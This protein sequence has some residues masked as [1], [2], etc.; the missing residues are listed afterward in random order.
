MP[1]EKSVER[2]TPILD[3]E[4]FRAPAPSMA[5][6][7]DG[8]YVKHPDYARLLARLEEVEGEL[9]KAETSVSEQ[10]AGLLQDLERAEAEH[11]AFKERLT[12]DRALCAF[13]M[14]GR[15]ISMD[16]PGAAELE[17]LCRRMNA[18]IDAASQDSERGEG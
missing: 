16:A 14:H 15:T 8:G 13:E 6:S 18:A 3:E 12:S 17:V 7:K 11:E 5:P 1:E 4:I 9:A 10:E 2:W